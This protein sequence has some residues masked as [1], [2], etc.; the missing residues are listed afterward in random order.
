MNIWVCFKVVPDFEQVLPSDWRDFSMSTDI[1]YAAKTINCFD[2][3]ALELA[4]RLK[5]QRLAQGLAATCRAITLGPPLPP[6]CASRFLPLAL[7]SLCAWMGSWNFHPRQWR[8]IW[9]TI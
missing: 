8:P 2:E 7:M 1:R 9:E 3:S 5:E 6:A 4:L